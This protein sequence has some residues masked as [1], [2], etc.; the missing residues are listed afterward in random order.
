[1][2]RVR[3]LASRKQE[4]EGKLLHMKK[5]KLQDRAWHSAEERRG[6]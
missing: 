6:T 4:A 2:I 1:M 3:E 5:K